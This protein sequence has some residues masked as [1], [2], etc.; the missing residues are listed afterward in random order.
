MDCLPL[1]SLISLS[2]ILS[3]RIQTF[4]LMI[5]SSL[6]CALTGG[7]ISNFHF[8]LLI[9]RFYLSLLRSSISSFLSIRFN[10][11]IPISISLADNFY[12]KAVISK[13]YG[14]E[15]SNFLIIYLR[16]HIF[17]PSVFDAIKNSFWFGSDTGFLSNPF[18][19]YN[20]I[21]SDLGFFRVLEASGIF[22]FLMT[23]LPPFIILYVFKP[24]PISTAFCIFI[25]FAVGLKGISFLQ[26]NFLLGWL[27]YIRG[28]CLNR[29]NC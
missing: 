24:S 5:F 2:Y 22:G 4:I 7:S 14:S 28:L 25:F 17:D 20:S 16:D 1:I 3:S 12:V 23:L 19:S 18:T 11:F 29:S 21:S 27:I 10:F 6:S 26:T 9:C 8:S 13:I 15:D